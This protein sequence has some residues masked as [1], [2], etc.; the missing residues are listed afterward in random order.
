MSW[1]GR[2][3]QMDDEID[4]A[5]VTQWIAFNALYGQWDEAAGEPLHDRECWRVFLERILGLDADGRIR[6]VLQADQRLVMSLFED[7]YLSDF[8]WRDP[9]KKRAGQSQK[10]KYEAR[11]WYVEGNWAL[12]LDHVIDRIYLI[13]CQLVHGAATYRGKLNRV[14]LRRCS[15][16]LGHVLQ[17]MLVVMIDHGADEDWG[18]MCYPPI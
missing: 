10:V 9:T 15:T 5:L 2:A 6:A 1:L 8:F 7:K 4:L 17:A 13:R 3:E 12:I 11:T 18:I 16:M 14:A